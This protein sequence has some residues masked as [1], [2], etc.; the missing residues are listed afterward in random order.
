MLLGEQFILEVEYDGGGQKTQ[1]LISVHS[2]PGLYIGETE[3]PIHKR[4]AT[5][6]ESQLVRERRFDRNVHI[7]ARNWGD[8][9]RY[10]LPSTIQSI[11]GSLEQYSLERDGFLQLH[12]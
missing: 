7:L 6:Q 10:N 5:T 12:N 2:K 9:L 3:Q 1:T 11:H 4:M 8:G